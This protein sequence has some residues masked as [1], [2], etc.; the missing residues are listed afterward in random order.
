MVLDLL[1]DR[2]PFVA[3]AEELFSQVETGEIV[4]CLSA[5]TVTT[6]HYLSMKELGSERARSQIE[7]LL[8]L[9]DVA[10]VHRPVL[11]GALELAFSDYE[12]AVLHEAARHWGADAVVTRNQQD[13]AAASLP[14][15]TPD[16]LLSGLTTQ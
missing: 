12:D 3:T 11:E 5:T 7:D 13:F 6:I 8:K 16:E 2:A 14:I 10:P 1:L 15:L 4:G 9:F